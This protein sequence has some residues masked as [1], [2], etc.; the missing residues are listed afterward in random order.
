MINSPSAAT[1]LPFGDFKHGALTFEVRHGYWYRTN[2]AAP[3]GAAG[4]YSAD[5][6]DD[7]YGGGYEDP[8]AVW[9]AR[10]KAKARARVAAT[11]AGGRRRKAP[12]RDP[13]YEYYRGAAPPPAAAARRALP[14][15][16]T[17]FRARAPAPALDASVPPSIAVTSRR[18][19]RV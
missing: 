13:E 5:Y 3:D 6:V 4:E 14:A 17:H 12:P 7:G 11:T 2:A 19:A 10:G 8:Y 15:G 9:P 16:Q 18:R 1:C